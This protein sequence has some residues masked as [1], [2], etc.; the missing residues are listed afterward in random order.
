MAAPAVL[1]TKL[2]REHAR[3]LRG[4]EEE[5]VKKLLR[6]YARARID[7]LGRLATLPSDRFSA[8]QVRI[9]LAQVT[10]G[11]RQLNKAL[12][13]SWDATLER[14][15]QRGVTQTLREIAVHD[16]T[17]RRAQGAIQTNVVRHLAAPK[18]L[19]L[20]QFQS[21]IAAYGNGLIRQM[22]GQLALHAITQ[23]PI[24]TTARALARTMQMEVWRAERIVRTETINAMNAGH[25]AALEG[26]AEVLPRLKKQW[27]ATEDARTCPTCNALDGKIVEVNG[28]FSSHGQIVAHPPVHPRCRCRVLGWRAEWAE[29]DEL[30]VGPPNFRTP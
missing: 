6:L 22:S 28:T 30:K 25:Q 21:S 26:A 9:T 27:D 14:R 12:G 8:Q 5:E 19:L 18:K 4:I 10:A 3:E 2:T 15:L 1:A 13:E 16:P 17:F 24:R 11:M 20:S 7:L 23:S 29:L